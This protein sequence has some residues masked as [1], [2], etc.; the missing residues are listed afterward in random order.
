[1]KIKVID[2]G[3]TTKDGLSK[4][5]VDTC[6]ICILRVRMNSILCIECGK[7]THGSCTGVKMV[8][9]MFS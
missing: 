8:M 3:G 9:A 6:G 1:M 5:K 2:S 4:G 7:W